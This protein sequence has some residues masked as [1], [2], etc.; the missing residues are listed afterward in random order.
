MQ[1]IISKYWHR[2]NKFLSIFKYN[3]NSSNNNKEDSD[4][5]YVSNSND[6]P[7]YPYL[8]D[9]KDMYMNERVNHTNKE[10]KHTLEGDNI[11]N[12]L[13]T[14]PFRTIF[15]PPARL[16]FRVG[17]CLENSNQ[18]PNHIFQLGSNSKISQE[19]SM[20]RP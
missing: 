19:T 10:D 14:V 18:K 9:E 3:N 15:Q 12:F 13:T 17:L 5:D 1:E 11:E 2:H 20:D 7:L 4:T 8:L 16:Y 6:E